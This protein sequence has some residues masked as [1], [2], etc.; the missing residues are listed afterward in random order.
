LDTDAVK[1]VELRSKLMPKRTPI[2]V[3]SSPDAMLFVAE[4]AERM[5]IVARAAYRGV[6]EADVTK[7][8][9]ANETLHAITAKLVGLSRGT[10][11]FPSED[12]L[13]S[14]RERAGITLASD[15]E[16]AITGA[17]EAVIQSAVPN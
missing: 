16:W 14:T 17:L 13:N 12:F 1:L 3:L 6:D 15:L 11:C 9:A 7:L 8:M 5:T 4:L 10:E 2:E